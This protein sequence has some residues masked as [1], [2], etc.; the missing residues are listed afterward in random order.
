ML[1]LI[2]AQAG[3]TITVRQI[4]GKDELRQHMA[5]MGLTVN[6]KITIVSIVNGN[7]ILNIKDS[8]VAIGRQMAMRIMY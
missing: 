8:R 4:R 7:M 5:E 2:S 3:E 6:S 1:P